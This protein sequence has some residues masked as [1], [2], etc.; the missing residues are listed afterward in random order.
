MTFT[1]SEQNER[2]QVLHTLTNDDRQYCRTHT[3]KRGLEVTWDC[4][5][6]ERKA[7]C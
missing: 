1:F 7:L 2:R 4:S 3:Q 6:R 5:V